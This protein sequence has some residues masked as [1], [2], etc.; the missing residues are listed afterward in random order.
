VTPIDAYEGEMD[1]FTGLSDEDVERVLA[2]AGGGDGAGW[3]ANGGRIG[4][5]DASMRE[6][7]GLLALMRSTYVR[8]PRNETASKHLAAVALEAAP[9]RI[10]S[11]ATRPSATRAD[12]NPTRRLRMTSRRLALLPTA[13]VGAFLAAAALAVAGVSLP[14]GARAPFD[15]LG[16]DLP[17]QASSSDVHAVIDA[18]PPGDRGCAFGQAVAA[19]ASQGH[20]QAT[21]NPCEH[22]QGGAPQDAANHGG[23]APHRQGGNQA[24]DEQGGAGA[25]KP[26]GVP[27]TPPA[28]DDFGHSTAADAQQNASTDG[29]AFGEG[30]SENAQSLTPAAPPAGAGSQGGSET[31]QVNSD[32]GRS[33]AADTPAGSRPGGSHAP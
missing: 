24:G 32:Q 14:D 1:D 9:L 13:A 26:A 7:V 21:G 22:E 6:V 31:G 8:P 23:S 29:R 4:A 27:P 33:T 10:A 20:A 18:T 25:G 3:R 30:T 5:D 2:F 16:I 28:G 11:S 15:E 17:N 19:A 12:R